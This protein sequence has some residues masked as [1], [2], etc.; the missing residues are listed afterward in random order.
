MNEWAEKIDSAIAVKDRHIAEL[1]ERI[2][3]LEEQQRPAA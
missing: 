1:S 3:R 2:R